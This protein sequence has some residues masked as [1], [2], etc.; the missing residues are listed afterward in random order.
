MLN[1]SFVKFSS[2]FKSDC[3]LSFP[4]KRGREGEKERFDFDPFGPSS[5][6][7]QHNIANTPEI[8]IPPD[9][10]WVKISFQH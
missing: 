2:L 1:D 10:E 3:S 7:T 5:S 4:T 6:A 8:W 9:S